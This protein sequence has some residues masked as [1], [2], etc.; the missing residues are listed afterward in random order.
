MLAQSSLLTLSWGLTAFLPGVAGFIVVAN[1][2]PATPASVISAATLV[3]LGAVMISVFALF[4]LARTVGKWEER[5]RSQC[6]AAA[7]MRRD[8]D[9]IVGKLEAYDTIHHKDI[10]DLRERLARMEATC[11]ALHPDAHN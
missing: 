9:T 5:M 11:K 8:L 2:T 4:R 10:G 3:P 1:T 6:D 7:T